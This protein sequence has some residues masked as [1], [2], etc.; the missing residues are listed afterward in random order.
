M[1][2]PNSSRIWVRS[3]E[4]F[5]G[6]TQVS[7]WPRPRQIAASAM[8]V[9]PLVGSSTRWPGA[10]LPSARA[11]SSRYFATRSFTEPV[12]LDPSSLRWIRYPGGEMVGS[13]TSGVLPTAC[14]MS[15]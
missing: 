10:S 15:S 14:A 11:D 3:S 8:P 4:V 5:S 13:P 9:L 1:S 12:G 7:G 6:I 2:A